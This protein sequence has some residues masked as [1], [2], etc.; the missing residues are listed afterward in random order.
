MKKYTKEEL[1]SFYK[2]FEQ[3]L[4]SRPSKKQ[5]IKDIK[6]PSL[7][8]VK[9][10]FGNWTGFLKSMGLKPLLQ[11]SGKGH[12]NKKGYI[13]LWNPKHPNAFRNGYI[14]EHCLNMSEKL[15]RPLKKHENVHHKNG[16]RDDNG[17]KNLE[18]WTISQP[19]GSRVEDKIEWAKD[20][21]EEYG[22][23]IYKPALH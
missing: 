22:Y 3:R 15:G 17:N 19:K 12:K 7:G 13:W 9:G 8:P 5:W 2:D 11:P 23:E 14:Q 10:R 20:F 18:L 21:L 16:I 4:E 1:I 6:T